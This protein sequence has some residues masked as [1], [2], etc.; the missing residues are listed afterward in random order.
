MKILVLN[1]GSSSLKYQLI[2]MET[3][4]VLA[5]GK[6]ERIGEKEAFITNKVNGPVSYTHLDVYKRQ[7]YNFPFLIGQGNWIDSEKLKPTDRLRRINKHGTLAIGFVGLAECLK[8]L[9]GTHHG[10]NQETQKLG[11]EIVQ[12]M[13]KTVDEFT[14]RNNLNFV[15]YATKEKEVLE[16]LTSID[17]SIYG[18][19]KGITDQ[20]NYTPGFEL[21]EDYN[22]G[23]KEKI[24]TEAPYHKLTNGGHIT[25]I[26]LGIKAQGK[27][28][29]FEKT[30]RMMKE[31]HI[32]YGKLII[33]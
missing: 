12:F 3:E 16:Y 30:V 8:A 33:N 15:L 20:K 11:I 7:V 32:G 5:S 6:Y 14:E 25:K 19:F 1:C 28:E 23:I 4:K 21:P 18:K 13:R 17:K 10:E 29:L 24:E 26:N 31:A 9:T 27:P 22:S 2:N